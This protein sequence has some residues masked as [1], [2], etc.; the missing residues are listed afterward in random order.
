MKFS[1]INQFMKAGGYEI[2]VPLSFLKEQ[3][4]N[5]ED[6]YGLELNPDFQRGHVWTKEQQIAWLEFF[7]RGGITSRVIYFNCPM[8]NPEYTGTVSSTMVCVDGLQRL[9]ALLGFLDNEIPI[10]GTLYEDFEDKLNDVRHSIKI[11]INNLLDKKDVI[12]WYIQMNTGGTVHSKKE[13][14]RVSKLLE[15]R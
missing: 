2:D 10:F 11:N 4:K 3:L 1:E 9:T 12:R 15:E 5:Y 8:F 7:F 14:E 6:R 13:I